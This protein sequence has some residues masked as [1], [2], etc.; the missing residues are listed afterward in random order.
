MNFRNVLASA[1]ADKTIKVWD[2]S[3]GKCAVTLLHH[4]GKAM[5]YTVFFVMTS[6]IYHS[7]DYDGI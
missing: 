3:A 2:L 5:I 6:V 1:S 7:E 4:D